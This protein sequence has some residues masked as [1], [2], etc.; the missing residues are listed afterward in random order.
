MGH[1]NT[2]RGLPAYVY[3]GRKP[4]VRQPIPSTQWR[5]LKGS[6]DTLHAITIYLE[7]TSPHPLS[8]DGEGRPYMKKSIMTHPFP[9]LGKGPGDGASKGRFAFSSYPGERELRRDCSGH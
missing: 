3:G 4:R 1:T 9:I 8:R 2:A 7:N 5:A 6:V